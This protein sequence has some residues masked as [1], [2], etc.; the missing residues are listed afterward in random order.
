MNQAF[1]RP[2]GNKAFLFA[3]IICVRITP[4]PP[5]GHGLEILGFLWRWC[6]TVPLM[7]GQLG[8]VLSSPVQC[9]TI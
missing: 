5:E 1:P 2:S 9:I 7:S 4:L 6:T 8:A 3:I